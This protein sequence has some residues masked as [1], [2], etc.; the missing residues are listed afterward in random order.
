MRVFECGNGIL[1]VF[2]ARKRLS[3]NFQV[4]NASLIPESSESKSHL[5]TWFE[6]NLIFNL[7]DLPVINS[8]SFPHSY[9]RALDCQTLLKF[10]N[11]ICKYNLKFISIIFHHAQPETVSTC[12]V[13]RLKRVS[14]RTRSKVAAQRLSEHQGH[15]LHSKCDLEPDQQPLPSIVKM[16]LSQKRTNQMNP[17]TKQSQPHHDHQGNI[18]L[19][20]FTWSHRT[21]SPWNLLKPY[22]ANKCLLNFKN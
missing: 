13:Q 20:L 17:M 5:E 15:D 11:N 22:K 18:N 4:Q 16:K 6:R 21:K 3:I 14:K 7:R 1:V 12:A 10:H 9:L 8:T 19:K 2:R